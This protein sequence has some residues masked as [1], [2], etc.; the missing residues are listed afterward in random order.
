VIEVKITKKVK[1]TEKDVT[2]LCI[3]NR[4]Q[5]AVNVI[6]QWKRTGA[7]RLVIVVDPDENTTDVLTA[8]G[9]IKKF[10]A[11]AEIA[12]FENH[13]EVKWPSLGFKIVVPDPRRRKQ[14]L[15]GL[16]N[17]ALRAADTDHITWIDDDDLQIENKIKMV[18]DA[19]KDADPTHVLV[20]CP[21]I[22]TIDAESGALKFRKRFAISWLE[23]IY[24]KNAVKP[25]PEINMSEDYHWML[26]FEEVPEGCG[27]V[28][29]YSPLAAYI[30]HESNV[31]DV[32]QWSKDPKYWQENSEGMLMAMWWGPALRQWKR[33]K[34]LW[35]E[36]QPSDVYPNVLA[37]GP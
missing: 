6:R 30:K 12:A 13:E 2:A 25:F 35:E 28:L 4:P 15:G 10:K 20:R 18:L 16:R 34:A 11:A 1:I 21:A 8:Y 29:T 5:F 32:S 37:T 9:K 19:V 22:P 23:G 3:T 33:D 7:G 36:G 17:M 26:Q 24:N 27:T 14:T 31:S